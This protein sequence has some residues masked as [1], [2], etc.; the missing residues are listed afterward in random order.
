[1]SPAAARKGPIFIYGTPW[2]NA[3]RDGRAVVLV[4]SQYGDLDEMR[5]GVRG[6]PVFAVE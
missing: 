5:K 3:R 1:M 6:F 4:T 2:K